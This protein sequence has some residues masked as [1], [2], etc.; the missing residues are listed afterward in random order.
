MPKHSGPPGRSTAAVDLMTDTQL[1]R[2]YHCTAT[3]DLV[4]SLV[5][6]LI[7]F[8]FKFYFFN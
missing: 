3:V 2:I 6:F 1:R 5:S 7:L 8:L 4:F